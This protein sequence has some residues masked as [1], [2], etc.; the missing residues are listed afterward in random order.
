VSQSPKAIFLL[1]FKY[2]EKTQESGEKSQENK[3]VNLVI[4]RIMF[5]NIKKKKKKN[6]QLCAW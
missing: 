6:T 3:N 2:E 5:V 1:L 4:W